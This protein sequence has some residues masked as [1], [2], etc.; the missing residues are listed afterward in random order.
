MII[1]NYCLRQCVY[2]DYNVFFNYIF[3]EGY[4]KSSLFVTILRTVCTSDL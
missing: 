2:N 4:Q 1:V 3:V